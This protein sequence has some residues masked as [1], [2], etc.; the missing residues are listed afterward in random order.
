MR[1]MKRLLVLAL[2]LL[3]PGVAL[4]DTQSDAKA[5][6]DAWV[7]AQTSRDFAAYTKL[8]APKFVGIRRTSDG[9]EKKMKLKA[10]LADRKKM[11]KLKQQDV[12]AE[13]PKITADDKGATITFL[14]RWKGG[15][16]ADH[17]GKIL[18][19]AY[20][21]GGALTI[22]HEELLSSTPGWEDDPSTTLDETKLVGP[23]TVRV[24]GEGIEQHGDCT[25]AT[26]VMYIKDKKG[27]TIQKEI[28]QGVVMS[29]DDEGGVT[30]M[31]IEPSAKKGVIF[32]FGQWCAGGGDYYQVIK[33]GDALVVR[34]KSADEGSDEP[35]KFTTTLTVQLPAGAKV[36]P[37]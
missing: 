23:I 4:A 34:Y 9:A 7:G 17:G 28:G 37:K 35:E 3:A 11:F 30:T 15:G 25:G 13:N 19:L 5:V 8:Y 18:K 20:D 22:M 1:R 2:L 24:K 32:D 14:Q 36:S 27:F 26:Y 29:D 12:V 21:K 10:W 31:K 6:L 33:S 16:Y